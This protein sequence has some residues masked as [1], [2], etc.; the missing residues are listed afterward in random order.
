MGEAVLDMLVPPRLVGLH[1]IAL[2]AM[3]QAGARSE[4][5]ARLAHHAE[6]ACDRQ[7]VLEFA[8]AAAGTT[9]PWQGM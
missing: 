7:A 9:L 6:G 8:P 5:L 2:D 1:R 3:L 4:L